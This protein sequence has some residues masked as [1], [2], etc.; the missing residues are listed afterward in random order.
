M[1]GIG[2]FTCLN[3]QP[4][5]QGSSALKAVNHLLAHR[6]PDDSGIWMPDEMNVGLAHQRLSI[7]DLSANG[8]QPMHAKNGTSIV[9]NGEIYNYLELRDSLS[10][11][12]QFSSQSDTETVLAAYDKYGETCLDHLRGMF[13]FALW[14]SRKRSLFCARDWDRSGKRFGS[15]EKAKVKLGFEAEVAIPDG[16]NRLVNWTKENHSRIENCISR[17]DRHL[18]KSRS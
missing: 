17:H 18:P 6:G 5:E 14:D 13:S 4:Y 2:G 12:W 8:S 7:I 1:C 15:T 11:N 16:I 10:G 9:L 3:N